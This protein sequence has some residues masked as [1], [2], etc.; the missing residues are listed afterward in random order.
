MVKRIV[1]FYNYFYSIPSND[2]K[3]KNGHINIDRSDIIK[4]ETNISHYALLN[5]YKVNTDYLNNIVYK[6]IICR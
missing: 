5:I 6:N 1:F 3:D 2:F 4:S